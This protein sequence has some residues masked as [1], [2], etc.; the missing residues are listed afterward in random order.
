MDQNEQ[1]GLELEVKLN[2]FLKKLFLF[3]KFP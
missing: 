1:K 3:F 2:K